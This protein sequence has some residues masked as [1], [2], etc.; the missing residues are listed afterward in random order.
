LNNWRTKMSFLGLPA[1]IISLA[2]A[3]VWWAGIAIVARSVAPYAGSAMDYFLINLLAGG[4][5]LASGYFVWLSMSV[6]TAERVEN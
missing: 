3:A 4:A 5:L 6:R 1:T 2:L